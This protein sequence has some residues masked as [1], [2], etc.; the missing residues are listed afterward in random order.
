MFRATRRLNDRGSVRTETIRVPPRG[1]VDEAAV[2]LAESGA[3]EER[4][5]TPATVLAVRNA[6]SMATWRACLVKS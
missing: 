1:I 5:A 6:M 3:L 2:R 4:Q